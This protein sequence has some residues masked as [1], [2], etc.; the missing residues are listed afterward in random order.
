MFSTDEWTGRTGDVWA[1]EWRRTD[2]SFDGL[3]DHLNAAI[4][5]V[6]PASGRAVDLGCGAGATSMALAIARPD[7]A[8]TGLDISPG[9]VAVAQQ[10]GQ[11]IANLQFKMA[12][13]GMLRSDVA[14]DLLVSRHGVMFYPNPVAAFTTIRAA[15]RPG[16]TLVFSCFRD[17]GAN[18]WALLSDAL[19]G[20]PAPQPSGYVPGPFAFAD[21]TF[22][23]DLL[24]DSG[25]TNVAADPI[26][27]TYVA[28]QGEDPVA[29]AADFC[30]RIGPVA[31]SIAE[32]PADRRPE[33]FE[34]LKE[35]LAR[36]LT[37][38]AVTF[39]AAAWIWTATNGDPQ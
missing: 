19:V 17:R 8:V 31:R 38:D 12:D 18:V 2:R 7:L 5:A 37:G 22:V 34:R 26:D 20:A 33:L 28:G 13:T 15:S 36:N 10:R 25:W 14:P 16:A 27:Y 32:Q 35:L 1:D 23:T 30:R 3:S 24:T 9:L 29:D 11:G 4:L 6:A 39:P 21:R